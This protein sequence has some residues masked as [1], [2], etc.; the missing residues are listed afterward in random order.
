MSISRLLAVALVFSASCV[1]QAGAEDK[2]SVS[3]LRDYV[4]VS[5]EIRGTLEVDKETIR[6]RVFQA[7]SCLV[8]FYDV[9]ELDFGKD[10]E[11]KKAAAKLHGRT[12][13]VT[14]TLPNYGFVGFG[15]KPAD[16][17]QIVAAK[18]V[19]AAPAK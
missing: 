1:S 3:P 7:A 18:S 16:T 2:P 9:W 10:N 5:A 13:V 19:Q 12:V 4:K 14:G 17:R 11:L 15:G 8:V 6:V